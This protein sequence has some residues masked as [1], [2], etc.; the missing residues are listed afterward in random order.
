VPAGWSTPSLG[1]TSSTCGTVGISGSTIQ[2]T[3]VSLSAGQQCTISYHGTAP[4]P[5]GT[6]YTFNAQQESTNDNDLLALTNSPSV[7]VKAKPPGPTMCVVPKLKGKTLA[8]ARTLLASAHCSL[9]KVRKPKKNKHHRKL[10]VGS[11]SPPAGTKL[12]KGSK[13]AVKL[14]TKK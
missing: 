14:V 2:V 13:V 11:T 9:G 4:G 5:G 12:P 1:T 10:V 3:G 6:S 7:L 8:Q